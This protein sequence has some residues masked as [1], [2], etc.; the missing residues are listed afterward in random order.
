MSTLSPGKIFPAYERG[1]TQTNGLQRYSTFNFGTY[2]NEN[3]EPVSSLYAF[4]DE[5]LAGLQSVETVVEEPS[6]IAII[7]VT[8]ALEYEVTQGSKEM[9][10]VGEI[11]VCLASAHSVIKVTNPYEG[12]WINYLQLHI[13]A[14]VYAGDAFVRVFD[15]DIEATP[16]DLTGVVS[17]ADELP[18][19]MS[20]GRF[21][22]RKETL[23]KPRA[24]AQVFAF[25]LAGA[26]EIQGRLLHERDGLALWDTAEIDMEALSNNALMLIIET[27]DMV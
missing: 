21:E 17:A 20:I 26:F 27:P 1:L 7:P 6:Y 19:L 12:D 18:F 24:N 2:Y 22:G 15:F 3:K 9:I 5:S 23:Y 13:K 14:P 11:Y 25:A 8:G 16:D 10:D 4:N